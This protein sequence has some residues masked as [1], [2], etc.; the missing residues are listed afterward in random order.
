MFKFNVS[1][2]IGLLVFVLGLCACSSGS[3]SATAK[4]VVIDEAAAAPIEQMEI[5]PIELQ[6]IILPDGHPE[7]PV[8]TV[9]VVVPAEPAYFEVPVPVAIPDNWAGKFVIDHQDNIA[10]FLYI[11]A[12]DRQE[13]LFSIT[14]LAEA[15][16]QAIQ[17]EPHGEAL[18][19]YG[20]IVWVYN[21]ALENPLSGEQAEEFSRMVGEAYDIAQSL[22]GFFTPQ[23]SQE[24]TLPVL[25]T[26]F[27]VLNAGN[28]PESARIFGGDYT[29][30]I[31]YNPEISPDDGAA[32]FEA[33]CTANG[34]IC[35]LKINEILKSEPI[36]PAAI[37]FTLI[38]QNPDGSI[39]EL[40]PCC[41]ADTAASPPQRE[42]FFTVEWQDGLFKVLELPVYIP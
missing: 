31:E 25:Q 5:I 17:N 36:S 24:T 12:P 11:V 22:A 21:P 10:E 26:Y 29:Q 40:G 4:E 30:L 14:A 18:L 15:E 8:E 16:W 2:L 34:F 41:G 27:D 1:T 39:F 38:L 42:F 19:N 9:W 32:L 7:F 13:R 6:Q 28:Y 23:I 20:G 3:S 33:A 35:S 37:Q